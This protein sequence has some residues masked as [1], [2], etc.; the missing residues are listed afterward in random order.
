MWQTVFDLGEIDYPY[1]QMSR[2]FLVGCIVSMLFF[3]PSP[4]LHRFWHMFDN[5][6][7]SRTRWVLPTMRFAPVALALYGL[8]HAI[9]LTILFGMA[10]ADLKAGTYQVAEGRVQHFDPK[11]FPSDHRES[12]DVNG[13]RF[14]YAGT[15][16][17]VGYN[18]T[19]YQ[20]G[21]IRE[22]LLVRIAHTGN[23]ILRL[24]IAP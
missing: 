9:K 4:R 2:L 13:V 20:G 17:A 16:D 10:V 23:F 15:E 21:V 5:V 8:F 22:G 14:V 12:F 7:Y 18:T 3:W 6:S 19:Y 24:E 11:R 1:W